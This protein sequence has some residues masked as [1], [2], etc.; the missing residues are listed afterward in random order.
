MSLW[1]S[2][3]G[4]ILASHAW[5][6]KRNKFSPPVTLTLGKF[7]KFRLRFMFQARLGWDPVDKETSNR[8]PKYPFCMCAWVLFSFFIPSL[9]MGKD[10]FDS[11]ILALMRSE[12]RSDLMFIDGT[13]ELPAFP[14]I[15]SCNRD[16][17]RMW[18]RATVRLPF[19][20]FLGHFL[21]KSSHIHFLLFV[22]NR[23]FLLS[24]ELSDQ[25]VTIPT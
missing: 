14:K 25:P 1:C 22:S 8:K 13:S 21:K 10:Q 7:Q 12:G 19:A 15:D 3:V 2:S 23:G 20:H 6:Y 16:A 9:M 18:G 11:E 5:R 17:M 24:L 4:G